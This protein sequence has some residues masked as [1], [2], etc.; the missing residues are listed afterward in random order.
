M[1]FQFHGSFAPLAPPPPVFHGSFAPPP[2][3]G[4]GGAAPAPA[5]PGATPYAPA[6]FSYMSD[7]GYVSSLAAEQAGRA[8]LAAA[9]RERRNQ[10]FTAF[11]DPEWAAK[12]GDVDPQAIEAARSLTKAGLSAKAR[13]DRNRK[14][15]RRA[16]VNQLAARGML[17]SGELGFGEREEEGEYGR[18]LYDAQQEV[19]RQVGEA[20]SQT[21][22]QQQQLRNAVIASLQQAYSTYS[23][24]PYLYSGA[25]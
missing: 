25:F 4:G 15:R 19:M 21:L 5:P 10:A 2:A 3:S 18:N 11:G 20:Q 6:P 23:S 22:S 8:S 12:F 7:P 13:L 17:R 16:L 24:N 14:L 9:L 1:P